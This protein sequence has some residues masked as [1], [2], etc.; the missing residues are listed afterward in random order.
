MNSTTPLIFLTNCLL[1][2]F[3]Y[4]QLNL[5]LE[6][7]AF[8]ITEGKMY[9]HFN[10]TGTFT[11]PINSNKRW[12]NSVVYGGIFFCPD[13]DF[14]LHILDAYHIC[15]F[16]TLG[17]NH[18]KDL[19][20]R[21]TSYIIPIYFNTLEELSKLQYKEGDKIP[22]YMYVGNVKHPKIAKRI[23]KPF[24]SYRIEDG[25]DVKHF[26]NLYKELNK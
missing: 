3:H 7:I 21:I 23:Y 8:G 9:K 5:P 14:Y 18:I 22:A 15:S 6:F 10:N 16:N 26:K 2:P 17:K 4:K 1:N 12:G 19:H 11:V 13:M 24:V 25:I 20:H